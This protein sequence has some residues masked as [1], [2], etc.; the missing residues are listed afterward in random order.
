M[1]YII[2]GYNFLFRYKKS[3]QSLEKDRKHVIQLISRLCAHFNI[4]ACIVFDSHQ[5]HSECYPSKAIL[6]NVEIVYSPTSKSADDYIIEMIEFSKYKKNQTVVTS[7][8][9]L[10]KQIE[11]LGGLSMTIESFLTQFSFGSVQKEMEEKP[12]SENEKELLRLLKIFED[13]FI[14]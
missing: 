1:Q 11:A 2:D 12:I 6:K 9:F 3:A 7:D 5:D 13:R 14:D 4:Q 8:N 10:R